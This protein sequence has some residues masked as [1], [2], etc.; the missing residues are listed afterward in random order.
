MY[1]RQLRPFKK[2]TH[3]NNKLRQNIQPMIYG[4]AHGRWK[5]PNALAKVKLNNTGS[6]D[7]YLS[8]PGSA[9]YLLEFISHLCCHSPT[10]PQLEL[11]L[12]LIM[13]RPPTHAGTFK[14]LPGNLY[15]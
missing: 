15:S 11:E 10:Q 8:I 3:M 4:T 5:W 6:T 7:G 1:F 12:D 14:A 9:F 2:K 13:G